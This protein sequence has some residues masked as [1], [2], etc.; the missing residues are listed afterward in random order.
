MSM[1]DIRQCIDFVRLYEAETKWAYHGTLLEKVPLIVR[2]GLQSN[3]RPKYSWDES[4]T[5]KFHLLYF[6]LKGPAGWGVQKDHHAKP[7]EIVELRFPLLALRRIRWQEDEE[8]LERDEYY[9]Q[10]RHEFNIPSEQIQ[11]L[12]DEWMSIQSFYQTHYWDIA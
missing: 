9:A 8:R 11:I 7:H 10:S 2:Y 5:R 6:S 4:N 12:Y 3:H 1:T